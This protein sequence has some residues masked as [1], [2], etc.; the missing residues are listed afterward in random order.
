MVYLAVV[1]HDED[2]VQADA[3]R[4]VGHG[5]RVAVAETRVEGVPLVREEVSDVL[6]GRYLKHLKMKL[7]MLGLT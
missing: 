2:A 5:V 6:Q 7:I 4:A 1:V 3:Y